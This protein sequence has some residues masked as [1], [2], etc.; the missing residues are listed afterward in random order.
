MTD[1]QRVEMTPEEWEQILR[2]NLRAY[3]DEN[4]RLWKPIREDPK[5][6]R[7]IDIACDEYER[8][9]KRCAAL[10]QNP[11]SLFEALR[12]AITSLNDVTMPMN[13]WKD[14]GN[15]HAL[16]VGHYRLFD[17]ED[18]SVAG[19]IITIMAGV[20]GL[21]GLAPY[22]D[23]EEILHRER[24]MLVL[25]PGAPTHWKAYSGSP[26]ELLRTFVSFSSTFIA[27]CLKTN[28]YCDGKRT[29]PI[30]LSVFRDFLPFFYVRFRDASMRKFDTTDLNPPSVITCLDPLDEAFFA[31]SIRR[32]EILWA[33]SKGAEPSEAPAM[34]VLVLDVGSKTVTVGHQI[35]R[36]KTDEQCR[37]LRRLVEA[38]G[39]IVT[40]DDLK[41]H[42]GSDERPDKIIRSM[43]QAVRDK[44]G[45]SRGHGGGYW[46]T[47]KARIIGAQ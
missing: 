31:G 26:I 18:V 41:E 1:Q 37:V 15:L 19:L 4:S 35:E 29:P 20:G 28:R 8:R 27:G 21:E 5:L 33:A 3:E 11:E 6:L 36:L 24:E 44:I 32:F 38:R 7:Y 12:L 17:L 2:E 30:P 10:S 34:D 39:S 47:C 40:S 46:I 13:P 43:P 14:F 9:L 45:S 23:R 16:L 22:L 42:P 25:W